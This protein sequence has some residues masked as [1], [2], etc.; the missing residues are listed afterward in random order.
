MPIDTAEKRK[1][2]S[3]ITYGIPGVTPNALADAEWRQEA[4]YS[5]SGIPAA[6][7]TLIDLI[8]LTEIGLTIPDFVDPIQAYSDLIKA[9]PGVVT[10]W[11]LGELS[12]TVAAE[13]INGL[14]GIYQGGVTLNKAGALVNDSN[15]AAGF[16]GI[17]GTVNLQNDPLIKFGL[18]D[19]SVDFWFRATVTNGLG[20]NMVS[21][22]GGV[23]RFWILQRAN[24]IATNVHFGVGLS[25]G[26]GTVT[27]PND[28]AWH[29]VCATWDRDGFHRFYLD[30]VEETGPID[31]S[32]AAA[33]VWDTQGFARVAS[34]TNGRYQGDI[35]EV[36][37]YNRVLTPADVVSHYETGK[38][39]RE[40]FFKLPDLENISAGIPDLTGI[41]LATSA[42]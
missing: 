35:D 38:A 17:D 27:N 8:R 29:Y 30:A 11:R 20:P 13:E 21:K 22:G 32:P 15:R 31:I 3:G 42:E 25:Y 37:F 9:T 34:G 12:G 5:Y 4:G 14:D 2:I 41:G 33:V 24:D 23:G 16:D 1:S 40:E 39:L 19:L 36:A 7:T 18:G 26:L 28:G 10:Y 6:I